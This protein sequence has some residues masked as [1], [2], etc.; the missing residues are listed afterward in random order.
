MERMR[1]YADALDAVE[2]YRQLPYT[3]RRRHNET[4]EIRDNVLKSPMQEGLEVGYNRLE[5]LLAE[6][7]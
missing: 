6:K 5:V 2:R 1:R 3:L 4:A 7:A